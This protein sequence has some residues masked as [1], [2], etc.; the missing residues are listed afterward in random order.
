M[1]QLFAERFIANGSSWIDLASGAPV[2]I[3]LATAGGTS[4]QLAWSDWCAEL[5]QLR[6]PVINTLLDYGSAGPGR[7]FEA[8]AIASPIRAGGP[9]GSIM[10]THAVRFL[11]SRGLPLTRDTAAAALREVEAG[12]RHVGRR[13]LGI[14]LQP[15]RV[16]QELA[17]AFEDASPGGIATID[18]T[19]PPG[20]GVRTVRTLA[21]RAARLNG[22]VPVAGAMLAR[23]LGIRRQ[24]LDRHVCV[25]VDGAD[26]QAVAAVFLTRLGTASGRRQ[27]LL[28]FHRAPV[29]SPSALEMDPLGVT[30]MT[31]MV[32][33]DRDY[34]PPC[35]EVLEAARQAAGKPG[36]FLERLRAARFEDH[37][38]HIT[39]VHEN[40][41]QYGVEPSVAESRPHRRRSVGRA[42]S[43]APQRAARLAARGRHASAVRLLSRASRV[44]EGRG[45]TRLA[46]ACA[47]RNGW[48]ARERG[49]SGP[50]IEQFE[51]ARTL[52]SGG[53]MEIE[54]A[55]GLGVVWT[56]EQ[57]FVEA[58]AALR[59]AAAAAHLMNDH[60]IRRWAVR[61]LA[62]CLHSQSRHD[63]ALAS[64]AP[65]LVA[66][67]KDATDEWRS[68]TSSG[69]EV[70]A[71]ALAA[72]IRLATRDLRGAVLAAGEAVQLAERLGTCRAT[73]TAARSMAVV[74]SALGDT[75]QVR[76]SVERGLTAAAAAHL[77]LIGL[78][79]RAVLLTIP[80]SS[81]SSDEYARLTSR[82]RAA[83]TYRSLPRLLRRQLESACDA[84]AATASVNVAD[85]GPDAALADL[86]HF[87]ELA[88]G[89]GDDHQAMELVCRTL[90]ERLRAASVQV[91]GRPP[92]RAVLARTGR[93]WPG[94]LR[95]VDRI[96]A[97]GAGSGADAFGG[98]RPMFEPVRYGQELIA[99]LCCRWTTGGTV[100][101][102]G[103]AAMLRAATLALAAPAR[104]LLDRSRPTVPDSAW[105]DLIGASAPAA[106]LRDA[107][108]RAARAP[109]P[110][111][112]EGESGSGK[113]L[114]SRAI[115]RLSAR[116]DRR[117]CTINC[118][119]LSDDLLEA[120]LFGHAR[121]AFTGAVGDRAGLFEEAD[122]G[123]LF[124]DEVGELSPRAQ[125]KL[126][127]VLQD[128]EVRRVGENLP[129]RVDARIVAAT[130]RRLDEEASAGRFRLDL[131][132]RLDVVRIAV[133]PLRD[134]STD[135]PA[136]VAHFWSESAARVGS[137][138]TL[139]AETIA[140]LTRYDWPGNIR[141]LQ[142]VVASL[143]V[144]APR[145]GRIL[146]AMLPSHVA[147]SSTASATTFEAARHDF[148]RRFV[149]AALAQA[150]GQRT[151][152][153]RALGVS[154]QG[155]AKMINRLGIEG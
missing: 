44:L 147:R 92:E 13:V 10:L 123:T 143:A 113:E 152:A 125:A 101:G 90:G 118:A 142:N 102:G 94:D 59:S 24:L 5:S 133:P 33:I 26:D 115:H 86:R 111:L 104:G 144:H 53:P 96:F 18:I 95:A 109:F 87:L 112:I 81:G 153:A 99:V 91:V 11:E 1:Q 116:R 84:T 74:Q 9:S 17:E 72:R 36:A 110:V 151:R 48:I 146:P 69:E 6:H 35:E 148:E 7:I 29:R 130:N 3:R 42:L 54:A 105:K 32:F 38:V 25:L 50:A 15:R 43:D 19:G 60:V 31:A 137:S 134:R 129:R 98:L 93:P 83:L 76:Q 128:G 61:A 100:D 79:L 139:T 154:R 121:G 12:T 106:S 62:R 37:R 117:L 34:G 82:L 124:L 55:I 40:S 135:I 126:L 14:H 30:A 47:L 107:I 149:R 89:A 20:S 78:C 51:R 8:Y 4:E 49:R 88:Q 150:G 45:E 28:R 77:P 56:D 132:F 57:R 66:M 103:A 64:L 85:N 22:Y 108:A 2:R 73:A 80:P 131:R 122:G 52:L 41:A 75:R 65:A 119:A 114:V 16:L 46:A 70:A 127:R 71:W 63:E 155:L 138:A 140:A 39:L 23:P 145:R 21:A 141:E 58:E 97:G 68:A 136:L 120:E 27:L 67:G